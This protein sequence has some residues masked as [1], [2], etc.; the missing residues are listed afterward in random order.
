M[1][2]PTLL[3]EVQEKLRFEI[4]ERWF[5]RMIRL[6]REP[7]TPGFFDSYPRFFSTSDTAAAPD[8]LNQRYRA[9]IES[10][11]GIISGRRVIDIASHDG[12]W[13]LAAHKVGAKHVLGIEARQHLVDAARDNVREYGV[14]ASAVEFMQGDVMVVLDQLECGSIDTVFC[15]GFLYH[16]IDHMP[17]FRKIARLKP[18]NLIVDTTVSLRPGSV[19][20]VHEEPTDHESMAAFGDLE[21]VDQGKAARAIKGYPSKE[22]LEM[23]LKAVGF[24]SVR[25]FDWQAAKIKRW[26]DLKNYYLGTRITV[27]ATADR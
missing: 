20:E 22:A 8:R 16:T 27:T 1:S 21:S 14:P 15:F 17:L 19:V 7:R 6:K 12:R 26:D 24:S 4:R 3:S 23:M 11:T 10:N 25:Y 2:N 18:K 9:L 13:S 5:R